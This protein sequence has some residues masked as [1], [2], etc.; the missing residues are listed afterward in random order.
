VDIAVKRVVRR[1]ARKVRR[2]AYSHGLSPLSARVHAGYD[3]A[4]SV[5]IV[6][7]KRT[8]STW[9]QELMSGGSGVCPIFEPLEG[10]VL[11]RRLSRGPED[12]IAPDE[13]VPDLE[14][15]LARA[16]AGAHVTRWA[17][18]LA[19]VPRLLRADRFVVKHVQLCRATGWL[20]RAFP[21]TPMVLV[22]RHPCAV[23]QSM[24]TVRWSG[25]SA[26]EILAKRPEPATRRAVEILD[27]R[28]SPAEVFAALWAA[29]L[30]AMLGETDPHRT[31]LVA[32][33]RVVDDPAG[34][35]GPLMER[36]RLPRP[37]DLVARSNVPSAT[38]HKSSVVRASGDRV[39]GW[40]DRLDV[41]DRSAVLAVVRDA[42]I[43][44]YGPD[45]RPD[46]E[47]LAAQHAAPTTVPDA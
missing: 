14:A 11:A 35:L 13:V 5:T 43:T 42:G 7:S 32:Y 3:L 38:T 33:E 16:M 20:E 40:L 37:P 9:V 39:S 46:L 4:D 34:A 10:D 24:L 1:N 30:G 18:R 6:A 47:A 36:L 15:F 12:V 26:A 41:G 19:S 25:S 17:M 28:D 8:G 31:S 21:E 29:E 44:G 27:G 2:V 45:P 23:V 22:V